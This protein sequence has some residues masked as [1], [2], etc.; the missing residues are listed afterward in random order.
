MGQRKNFCKPTLHLGQTYLCSPDFKN[1]L[2]LDYRLW[3]HLAGLK[4]MLEVPSNYVLYLIIIKC[5]ELPS[6]LEAHSIYC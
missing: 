6:K 3:P 5:R 2:V 4:E 1:H